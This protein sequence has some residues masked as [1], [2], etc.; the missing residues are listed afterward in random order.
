MRSGKHSR[1]MLTGRLLKRELSEKAARGGDETAIRRFFTS[2][3]NARFVLK[4]TPFRQ[5]YEVPEYRFDD[6]RP[7]DLVIDIGA[8]VGAFCIRASR[9]SPHVVAI[10]PLTTSLLQENIRL[11]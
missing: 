9:Y 3:D 4:K 1:N 7:H 10:E 6:L 11:N 2:P 5:V 8:N